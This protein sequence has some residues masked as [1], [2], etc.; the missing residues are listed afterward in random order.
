MQ[1]QHTTKTEKTQGT[2]RTKHVKRTCTTTECDALIITSQT[3][4]AAVRFPEHFLRAKPRFRPLGW[5]CVAGSQQ[6]CVAVSRFD[7]RVRSLF[8]EWFDLWSGVC[9][10]GH[11]RCGAQF[12]NSFGTSQET[13]CLDSC[14]EVGALQCA[15]EEKVLAELVEDAP[16]LAPL[17]E[18]RRVR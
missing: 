7:G 3:H 5:N 17:A 12:V 13:Q 14:L 10:E 6:V 8:W 15:S 9:M 18:E 2:A 11:H 1:L 4:S 16:S